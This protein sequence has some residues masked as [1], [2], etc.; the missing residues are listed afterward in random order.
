MGHFLPQK[1]SKDGSQIRTKIKQTLVS[2]RFPNPR[3]QT[4]FG[5]RADSSPLEGW[6]SVF[7]N[8]TLVG[9]FLAELRIFF[10]VDFPVLSKSLKLRIIRTWKGKIVI[11]FATY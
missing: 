5:K 4:N 10:R 8:Y 7:D 3:D 9:P 6:G 2:R 1:Y 11:F